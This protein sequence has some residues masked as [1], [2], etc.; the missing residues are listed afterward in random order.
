M[1][2]FN[3]FLLF[4][5]CF[6]ALFSCH[7]QQSSK[8][9]ETLSEDFDSEPPVTYKMPLQI[10]NTDTSPG[11]K[12]PGQ[13]ILLTGKVLQADQQ[14][15]AAD[16]LLY[17]YHTDINGV[18]AVKEDEPLNM[19]KN[20][21]GQTHG[22]IRGWMRTNDDGEY[23]IYTAMP[24]A[25]PGRTVPA[26]VHMYI[27]EP[28]N[29]APYYIDDFVFNNDTLLT[30]DYRERM[31]NRGGSGIVTFENAGNLLVGKR[32]IILGYNVRRN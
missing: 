5:M 9:S 32:D 18:Y 16:V 17:Y 27:Q 22:Y 19:P 26:H 24:G 21:L 6:T 23:F 8:P 29:A 10:N 30:K 4:A 3:F 31:T 14:T 12:Q 25:Y 2:K 13:K 1:K 20:R 7:S 11:W 28:G 15:P